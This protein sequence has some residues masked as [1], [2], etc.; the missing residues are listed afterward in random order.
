MILI[1][2]WSN[3]EL[4]QSF[5]IIDGGI[6]D[7]LKT[8]IAATNAT[9]QQ[10]LLPNIAK[11]LSALIESY[12]KTISATVKDKQKLQNYKSRLISMNYQYINP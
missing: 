9:V 10:N 8:I 5:P 3:L 2:L 7:V 1:S 12:N 11:G 6:K 4:A